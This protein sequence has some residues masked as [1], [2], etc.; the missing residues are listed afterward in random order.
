MLS[1]YEQKIE[2]VRLIPSDG[3]RFEVVIN[4]ELVYSKVETGQH[5]EEGAMAELVGE[6]L[7]ERS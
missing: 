7:K 2:D 6:Y 4:G 5:M 1:E 3:G